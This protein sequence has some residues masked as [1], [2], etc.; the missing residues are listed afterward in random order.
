MW[1]FP[2]MRCRKMV[3]TK[4]AQPTNKDIASCACADLDRSNEAVD[5]QPHRHWW[6]LHTRHLK[7]W[8]NRSPPFPAIPSSSQQ[9]DWL[10]TLDNSWNAWTTVSHA[11]LPSTVASSICDHD[12]TSNTLDPINSCMYCTREHSTRGW[13]IVT[14]HT[15]ASASLL[16]SVEVSPS[17]S[18]SMNEIYTKRYNLSFNGP[19]RC[20]HINK[21]TMSIHQSVHY[22]RAP[23]S[24]LNY[25]MNSDYES[26]TW[27]TN[28]LL[29]I[30][31]YCD[32]VEKPVVS[33]ET[34]IFHS[35]VFQDTTP[36]HL[37]YE[38]EKNCSQALW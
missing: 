9:E 23:E 5:L 22:H 2:W 37:I 1:P 26:I 10:Q 18:Q 28:R 8:I 19:T 34:L 29:P 31:W 20:C 36:L 16:E 7:S 30:S 6:T 33:I 17:S 24:M 25:R 3:D 32:S 27:A 11:P 35:N 21:I 12:C 13:E 14:T 15:A 38:L 4:Q